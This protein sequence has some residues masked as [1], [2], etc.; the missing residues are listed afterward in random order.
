MNEAKTFS[1]LFVNFSSNDRV[2]VVVD[3]K[4]T[5]LCTAFRDSPLS[6]ISAGGFDP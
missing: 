4:Q 2:D 6:F 5:N 3:P 1:S